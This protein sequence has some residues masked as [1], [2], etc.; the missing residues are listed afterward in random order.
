MVEVGGG[1]H[2]HVLMTADCLGGVWD[3]SLTLSRELTRRGVRVTL[4]VLGGPPADDQRTAAARVDGLRVEESRFKLEW[5]PDCGDDLDASGRWLLELERRSRPDLVHVNGYAHAALPFTAPV[6]CVAH[7]CVR[8]WF[9]AVRGELAPALYDTYGDG[10]LRGLQAAGMIVAPTRA[11]AAQL[12]YHHG[13][14]RDVRVIPNGCDPAR[15]AG[16]RAEKQPLILSVGRIWDEAKNIGLLDGIAPAVGAAIAVAGSIDHPDGS[17]HPP[18]NLL[19]LGRLDR[20]TL[21]GWYAK[22][23]VF[24]LPARYEPFG[25]AA[26]EAGLSG[27][28]LVL[29]DIPSLRE[30]W[31]DAALFVRPTD[32]DGLK[33]TLNRLLADTCFRADMAERARIRARRYTAAAM[34]DGYLDAYGELLGRWPTKSATGRSA[35]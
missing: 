1:R 32:A 23:S 7:S 9:A 10:V 34:A 3:Y 8:S 22:A 27:C 30:V 15:F 31:G 6:L 4:A 2:G 16:M 5:M 11:M 33:R 21:D 18:G 19:H 29:G 12:A 13:V 28:A 35:A 26:L 25:L 20:V 17:T 14:A 24:C